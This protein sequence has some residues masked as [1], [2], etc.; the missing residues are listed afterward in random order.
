M[1]QHWLQLKTLAA[2]AAIH[3]ISLK[4]EDK[5]ESFL[6]DLRSRRRSPANSGSRKL[7]RGAVRGRSC[8][9]FS[10]RENLLAAPAVSADTQSSRT[11][12]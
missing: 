8:S 2:I 3:S 5:E 7:G 4:L 12:S 10:F 11:L 9:S 6:T 1:L